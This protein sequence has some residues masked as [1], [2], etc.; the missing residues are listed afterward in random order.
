MALE[1]QIGVSLFVRNRQGVE[2]TP[3]G[4]ALLGDAR[5]VLELVDQA[6]E[7]ARSIGSGKTGVLRVGVPATGLRQPAKWILEAFTARYPDAEVQ[8]HPGLIPQS[9]AALESHH[10]HVAFVIAPF[11]SGHALWYQPLGETELLLAVP[12]GHRLASYDRVPKAELLQETF[13][14]RPATVNPALVQHVRYLLFGEGGHPNIQEVLEIGESN[15]M[16][17]VAAGKGVTL[18]TPPDE[19]Q[20]MVPGITLRRLE[21]P[22]PWV[23][24]GFV[25]ADGP[26]SPVT[27][28]FVGLALEFVPIEPLR[29]AGIQQRQWEQSIRL[30]KRDFSPVGQPV[31]DTSPKSAISFRVGQTPLGTQAGQPGHGS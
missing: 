4:E 21:E 8:L 3:A 6:V 2:L 16:L 17:L 22:A 10:L 19:D 26:L 13:F 5:R 12:D 18:A 31:L 30:D 14:D 20:V 24:C 28:A 9:V 1:R 15:R 7:N 11:D 23:Q 27:E 29:T 25:W